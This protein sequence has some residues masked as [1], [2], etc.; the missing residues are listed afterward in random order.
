MTRH[1][2]EYTFFGV[3]AEAKKKFGKH[4]SKESLNMELNIFP[5]LVRIIQ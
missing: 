3:I 1:R 5:T 4:G 2:N